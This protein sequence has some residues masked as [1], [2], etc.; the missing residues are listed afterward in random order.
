MQNKVEGRKNDQGKA[1]WYLMPWDALEEILRAFEFGA[2][3]YGPWNF[4]NGMK[5]SRPFSALCRHIFAWWRGEDNDPES[6]LSHLAHAG[7][8]VV[9][10][11]VY[12]RNNPDQDDRYK[13][14]P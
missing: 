8:C 1:A 7:A 11:L 12:I 13:K 3:K 14:Q 10:L 6:G 5:W 4:R 9:M 2:E